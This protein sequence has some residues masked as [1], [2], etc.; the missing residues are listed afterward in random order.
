MNMEKQLENLYKNMTPK[1]LASLAFSHIAH[2]DEKAL[3][4]IILHVPRYTYHIPDAVYRHHLERISITA[5]YWGMT[6][7]KQCAAYGLSSI[8]EL[9]GYDEKEIIVHA[10]KLKAHVLA[11]RR[12]CDSHGISFEAVCRYTGI[13][14]GDDFLNEYEPE[15][16]C[17]QERYDDLER[18]LKAGNSNRQ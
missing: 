5:M 7:W 14:I 11:M 16:N 2:T 3:N 6:F 9:D 1:E 10:R 13:H 12:L 18:I 4:E 15:E 17:I 8:R